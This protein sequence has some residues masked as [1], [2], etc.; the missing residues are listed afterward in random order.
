MRHVLIVALSIVLVPG[1]GRKQEESAGEPAPPIVLDGPVQFDVSQRSTTPVPGSDGKILITVDDITRGQV[2]TTL[3]WDNGEPIVATRSARPND[4][5]TFSAGGHM[6]ELKL[7]ELTNVLVGDDTASFEIWP[8]GAG[9]SE[10]A[11]IERLISSLSQLTEAKFRRNEEEHTVD[12]A[13]AHIRSKLEWKRDEIETAEDFIR[14]VGSRSSVSD[15]PYVI[16]FSDGTTK[17]SEDWFREQL[18]RIEKLSAD[19]IAPK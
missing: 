9:L 16:E 10:D 12:E 3:S 2:L 17:N 19:N 5:I 4:V 6:Y 1:C 13:V 18:D 7:T 11:K 8:A 14:I 15:E